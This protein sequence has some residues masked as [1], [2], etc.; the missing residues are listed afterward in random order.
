MTPQEPNLQ[1]P[2]I[3]SFKVAAY[4]K[5]V[6]KMAFFDPWRREDFDFISSARMRAL[7]R[8]GEDPPI[9]FMGKKA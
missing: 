7:A 8:S 5:T 2:G 4:D 6:N 1:Q 3:M 9:G